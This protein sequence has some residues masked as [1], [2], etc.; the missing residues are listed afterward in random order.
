MA[1]NLKQAFYATSR[2]ELHGPVTVFEDYV[3]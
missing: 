1:L 2:R 3:P